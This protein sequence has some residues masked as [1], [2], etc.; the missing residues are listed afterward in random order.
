MDDEDWEELQQCA[1]GTMRLCLVD[2]I[3]YHVMNLKSPG[4]VWKKLE[5]QFMSKS[6]TNK[7]YLKQRLYGLKMQEGADL[8]QHVNVFNQIITDL[9]RPDVSIEDDDSPMILLCSLPFSYEHLVT[10]LTYGKKTIK[11]VEITA[12]LLTYNQRKQ[13]AGESSHGDSLYVKGNQERR[14]KLED[15]SGK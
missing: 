7:L 2:E 5:I 4:E 12:A 6:I 3:M 8:A 10:T 1:T 14:R 15:G 9:T 13:N 11:V